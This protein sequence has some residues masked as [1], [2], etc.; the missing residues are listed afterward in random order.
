MPKLKGVEATKS[1][2]KIRR[3]RPNA[4]TVKGKS[5]LGNK[6]KKVSHGCNFLL[7]LLEPYDSPIFSDFSE[8]GVG[9]S[10]CV[11][12]LLYQSADTFMFL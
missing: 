7:D 5:K 11:L 12:S 6:G 3:K 4:T 1:H 9:R 10:S 8:F 2:K